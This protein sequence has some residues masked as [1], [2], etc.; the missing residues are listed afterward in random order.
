MRFRPPE[1]G[2]RTA[3]K[4]GMPSREWDAKV[5]DMA[6]PQLDAHAREVIDANYYLTL[7]TVGS[8]GEPWAS[9]VYFATDDYRQFYWVSKAD[10]MHSRNLAPRPAASLVIFDSTVRP[11]HGRAVYVSG[12]AVQLSGDQLLAAIAVY[13]GPPSRGASDVAVEDVT[14]SSPYRMYG[15]TAEAAHVLCPR[16]PRSPCPEH[17]LQEDHRAEVEPWRTGSGGTAR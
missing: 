6:Q 1:P 16:E 15:V 17:G 7:A 14:G 8:T 4:S 13:P 5:E 10:A 12:R 11:Y 9:P 3:D 2:Y